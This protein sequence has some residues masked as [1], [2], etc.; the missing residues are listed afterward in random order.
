TFRSTFSLLLLLPTLA[1]AGSRVYVL[2]DRELALHEDRALQL[3]VSKTCLKNGKLDC[4]ASRKLDE[5]KLELL[6]SAAGDQGR[7]PGSML[8]HA[9]QGEVV[10][11]QVGSTLK[12]ARS[13]R[14]SEQSFC[15]FKDGSLVDNGSLYAAAT[16]RNAR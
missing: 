11:V 10:I 9:L 3:Q 12:D 1:L 16:R 15:R 13:P 8:C 2:D 6:S 5:A 14:A 4:D 7:N